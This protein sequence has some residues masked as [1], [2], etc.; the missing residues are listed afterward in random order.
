MNGKS[1]NTAAAGL[2]AA[3]GGSRDNIAGGQKREGGGWIFNL[4]APV[5]LRVDISLI[6]PSRT[7]DRSR[8]VLPDRE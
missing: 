8:L 3:E 1:K 6:A 2:V 7:G 5:P 4:Q